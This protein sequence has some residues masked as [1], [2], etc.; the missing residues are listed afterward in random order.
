MISR[1]PKSFEDV[2][3]MIV[4]GS[5][6]FP[7]IASLG[8]RL[9][10]ALPAVRCT[11]V[12]PLILIMILIVLFFF[13]FLLSFTFGFPSHF[14]LLLNVRSSPLPFRLLHLNATALTRSRPL[15]IHLLGFLAHR[16]VWFLHTPCS[17]FCLCSFL[18]AQ[19]LPPH[20][21]HHPIIISSLPAC[22]SQDKVYPWPSACV[23]LGMW[24]DS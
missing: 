18:V 13:Y 14:R 6:S 9:L 16:S 2:P 4:P 12:L 7:A 8:R 24:G 23:G 20:D 11:V 22:A 3:I 15:S 19:P 5:V 10:P 1:R 17:H 21:Q